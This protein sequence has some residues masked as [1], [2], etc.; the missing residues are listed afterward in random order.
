MIPI[1]YEATETQFTSNGIGRLT[2]CISCTVTEERN[3]IFEVEF[4]YPVTGH[5]F[6]EI[7]ERRIISVTYD[8]SKTRQP[9]IIY[10]RS[11]PIDG[12]VTFY[13][14]H[15]SYELSHCVLQP[16]T[17]TTIAQAFSLLPSK[18]ITPCGFTFYTNKTTVA[19]FAI[20]VPVSI[21]EV[22]GGMEGSILD[23]FGGGEYEFDKFTVNLWQNR[24]ADTGVILR[25]RK[26][27]IDLEQDYDI[28]ETYNS[29]IPYW[30]DG[31]NVVTLGTTVISAPGTVNVV[32]VPMDL[33]DAF[34]EAPTT[35]Q[36]Q[37]AAQNRLNNSNSWLP[38]QNITV[39]FVSL[40]QTEDYKD[41]APLQS[42]KLCDTITVVHP[43]LNLTAKAKV[44]KTVYNTLLEKYDEIEIG[45][46]KTSF[47]DTIM[48]T[49]GVKINDVS[50]TA[51]HA[52]HIAD[53]TE[54]HFW[55]EETGTDTGAHIT[56]KTQ[57]AFIADRANGGS[58]LLARSNGVAVRDGLTELAIFSAS[59][60]QVG[61]YSSGHS[62]MDT[63]GMR[64][65]GGDGTT[66]LANLGYGEGASQSGTASAPYYTIGERKA[67]STIGN[68]SSVEGKN[69][70]ASAFCSHAEGFD[71]TASG[72][73]SHAEGDTTTASNSYAH[74][75]GDAT[76]ASGRQSHSEGFATVASGDSSHAGGLYTI[77]AGEAQTAI[78]K[79]NVQD[80][81]SLLIV[82][83]GA[84]GARSNAFKLSSGGVGYFASA[85]GSG[86]KTAW[87]D[88]AH[89]GTW[90]TSSGEINLTRGTTSGGYIGFHYNR[91]A[92]ATTGLYENVSGTLTCSGGFGSGGK[93]VWN[94]TD[95]TG[96]F[97][98]SGG[99]IH[100]SKGSGGGLIGFHHNQSASSTTTLSE[101]ESGVLTNSGRL[102]TKDWS[103]TG[104]T[105]VS[106]ATTDGGRISYI[107]ATAASLRVSG[108]WG[109][110]GGS[111]TITDFLPSTSD[112]RL[113][114][115]VEDCEIDDALNAINQIQMHS[116]DWLHT[117]EHQRIGFI[118]DELEEIDAKLAIGGGTEKD[119]TV[120]YKTVNTFYLL[121]Y[122]VKAVQELSEEVERLKGVDCHEQ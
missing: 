121:G 76:E 17:A 119:G 22:L 49:V 84:S 13:A 94:D 31:E 24:G 65:Y 40:W 53:N 63:N 112:I 54:Q 93:K 98:T 88:T 91:S 6:N 115:N 52:L 27:L 42:V 122:L 51:R 74:A 28:S 20:K 110:E 3:G 21:R 72:Q 23:V 68:W 107:Q 86:G 109:T 14:H 73:S 80:S 30:T 81:N 34:T 106:S 15:I 69:G 89:D 32:A 101:G 41:V 95:A 50:T 96:T 39:D 47:A 5:L 33:S 62:I 64:V 19:N 97:L 4:V 29:V 103:G 108:Q 61:L 59:G 18:S 9:F 7:Q 35:A 44:I 67:N 11:A 78:G 120:H 83:N 26:N 38:D 79:Y 105:P 102:V 77:A 12:N 60:A 117:D 48:T 100:M 45:D 56:E 114:K 71:T 99:E 104:R 113:K 10:S 118:A 75:E 92:S 55:M 66:Q 82:G 85:I 1:L 25:Y 116:F 16:F 36:L 87:N 2:E 90:I 37:T 70:T 58:N 43:E 57:D 111:Y 46:P 8:D